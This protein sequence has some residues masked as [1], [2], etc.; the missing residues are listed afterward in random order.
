A[1]ASSAPILQFQNITPCETFYKIVSDD[2]AREGE[3]C[4]N[5]I[6]KSWNVIFDDGESSSG[7]EKLT[8]IFHLCKPLK[9]QS[10]VYKFRDWLSST[11]VNLAMVNYPYPASFL[12]PLP[13]W[14]IK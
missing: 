10:D 11:W 6:K 13:A 2:F 9:N 3:T 7:R 8:D 12:E 1:I 14:P 5:L 4:F